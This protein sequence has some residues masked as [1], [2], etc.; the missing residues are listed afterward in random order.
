M[1]KF[2]RK[3]RRVVTSPRA[4]KLRVAGNF[5]LTR[6]A[7]RQLFRRNAHLRGCIAARC[8]LGSFRSSS[9]DC[10]LFDERFK[11]LSCGLAFGIGTPAGAPIFCRA[12]RRAVLCPQNHQAQRFRTDVKPL[13]KRHC[14]RHQR[15]STRF[16]ILTLK[17]CGHDG[18]QSAYQRGTPFT[19]R[20]TI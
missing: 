5:F 10:K 13:H 7:R 2:P 18:C 15:I 1:T 3:P 17:S 16:V 11:L 19:F 12:L 4:E 8:S 14:T 9:Q 6:R 20:L